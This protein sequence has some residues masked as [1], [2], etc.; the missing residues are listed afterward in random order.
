MGFHGV[1]YYENDYSIVWNLRR[2]EQVLQSWDGEPVISSVNQAIELYNIHRYFE[3]G[4]RLNAWD[5]DTFTGYKNQCKKIP[6][7]LGRFCSTITDTTIE[8]IYENVANDYIDDFWQLICNHKVYKRID[9][10]KIR[11][12]LNSNKSA[13]RYFLRYKPLV[14]EYGSIITECLNT[15]PQAA[16]W[17]ISHFLAVQDQTRKPLFF[18]EEFTQEMRDCVLN[19]YVDTANP[20]AN[21]LQLLGQGQSTKEFPISDKLKLKALERWDLIQRTHF[22][23]GV[24]MA[25]GIE[26]TFKSIPDGSV[27][28]SEKDNTFCLGYSLEWIEDNQDYATLLNNFI[29]LFGY[30]DHCFRCTFTSLKS[31]M[32]V[33]ERIVGLKG[34]KDYEAGIGFRFKNIQAL[35]Q[36]QAYL[37]LIDRFSIHI[38][39]IFKWF[40]EE[41]LK[42]EFNASGFTY[43]PPSIG[44]TYAEK[45]KLLVSSLDGVL[46]Q[47]RFFSE[48]GFIN[49]KL[50]EMSSCHIVFGELLSLRKKKY[51]Y[52]VSQNLFGEMNLLFSDQSM[53]SYTDKTGEKY[54]TLPQLLLSEE[55][56]LSDF[57]DF[58]LND[59]H[60]LVERGSIFIDE[61]GKLCINRSRIFILQDL[62]KNEVLCPSYFDTALQ[63]QVED[64]VASGDMEYDDTLFSKPEQAYLNYMLNKAEFSN[65]QNLRNKYI[66]DT[67]PLDEKQNHQDYLKLLQIMVLVIIKINE[68]FCMRDNSEQT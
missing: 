25:F 10:E 37:H 26:V 28:H 65:G 34:K 7:L 42:S 30:V 29:Y 54:D 47:Y 64:F 39:D 2:A 38:E 62:Y 20:N 36:L 50:L 66:H 60:W 8:S 12:I 46:K 22:D 6:K 1:K 59:L 43:T 15:H 19:D 58:Q 45:C 44:T 55:M 63:Q 24:Q 14:V 56:T 11:G 67:C 41:Y 21:F 3:C 4:A 33:L 32:G 23:E 35:M 48:D 31:D 17:L 27:E 57:H 68:E 13:L 53:L 40:F 61:G 18:P 49:R 5:D 16:E 51:A 9:A 52:G